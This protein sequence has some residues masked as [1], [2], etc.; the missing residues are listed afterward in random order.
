MVPLLWRHN[1]LENLV[2]QGSRGSAV[3]WHTF[4]YLSANILSR[5]PFEMFVG[6]PSN[7]TPARETGIWSATT[8]LS[9][10][11]RRL[12]SFLILYMRLNPSPI[13][14]CP[15]ANLRTIT[16]GTTLTFNQRVG[17]LTN[18]SVQRA[19]GYQPLIWLCGLCLTVAYPAHFAWCRVSEWTLIHSQTLSASSFSWNFIGHQSL[20]FI[21]S[22]GTKLWKSVVKILV[23]TVNTN[24]GH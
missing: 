24:I 7:S 18:Y 5:I 15:L 17:F 11:Y 13:T 10:S 1:F 22:Y 23:R 12:W 16:S 3:C 6:L 4:I 19:H 8:S 2:M 20:E 9:S 21:V 14:K